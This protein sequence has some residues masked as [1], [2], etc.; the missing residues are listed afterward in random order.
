MKTTI[1]ISVSKIHQF[2]K[3]KYS[4]RMTFSIHQ[5]KSTFFRKTM[6]YF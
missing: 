1:T 4:A 3:Q 5:L 6:L 2:Y